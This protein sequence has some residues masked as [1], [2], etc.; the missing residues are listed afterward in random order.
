M[1]DNLLSAVALLVSG[2][3]ATA[4][5]LDDYDSAH[6]DGAAAMCAQLTEGRGAVNG[7]ICQVEH[8][9]VW[10]TPRLEVRGTTA[11]AREGR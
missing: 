6:A 7:G 4:L 10:V 11:D 2:A 8:A 9:G 3:V 5:M 1:I